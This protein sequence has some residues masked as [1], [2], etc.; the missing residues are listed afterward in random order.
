MEENRFKIGDVVALNS[1]ER[2]VNKMTVTGI[3]EDG[4]VECGYFSVGSNLYI[5]V[6]NLPPAALYIAK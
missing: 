1:D 4:L 3:W 6:D 5:T 2:R